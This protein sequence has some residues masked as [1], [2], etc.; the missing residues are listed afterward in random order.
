MLTC[1]ILFCV[2]FVSGMPVIE[3]MAEAGS[4]NCASIPDELAYSASAR[5]FIILPYTPVKFLGERQDGASNTRIVTVS[6]LDGG[7]FIGKIILP[8][9]VLLHPNETLQVPGV[10]RVRSNSDPLRGNQPTPGNFVPN[11]GNISSVPS[12]YGNTGVSPASTGFGNL[13]NNPQGGYGNNP[14]ANFGN[15]GSNQP[16]S[17]G[18]PSTGFGNPSSNPPFGYG[19]PNPVALPSNYIPNIGNSAPYSQQ[20]A[21]NPPYH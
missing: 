3:Y 6:I 20:T 7:Q 10:N 17:F 4:V 15:S 14:T 18:N 5:E 19:N 2:C 21:G 11:G 16:S 8:T 1:F 13:G 12:G 9:Q